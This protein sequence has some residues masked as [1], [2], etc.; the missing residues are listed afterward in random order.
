MALQSVGSSGARPRSWRG[1]WQGKVQRAAKFG[2]PG[3]QRGPRPWQRRRQ[4][5]RGT[6]RLME[7]R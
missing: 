3:A 1:R 2:K 4:N 6:V 7:L 5:P